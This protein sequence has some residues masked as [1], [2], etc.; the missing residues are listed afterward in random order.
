VPYLSY[1]LSAIAKYDDGAR[2]VSSEQ[3]W[4]VDDILYHPFHPSTSYAKSESH[5]Q[6]QMHVE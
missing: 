5:N 3:S 4:R 6:L 1:S 2:I